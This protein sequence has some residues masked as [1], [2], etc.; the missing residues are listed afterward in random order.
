MGQAWQIGVS[1]PPPRRYVR[2]VAGIPP[3]LMT[4]RLPDFDY[5]LLFEVN[6]GTEQQVFPLR[7]VVFAHP[8]LERPRAVPLHDRML[9]NPEFLMEQLRE[10]GLERGQP[11]RA[12]AMDEEIPRLTAV[13][14]QLGYTAP[15][16]WAVTTYAAQKIS[17]V[18][19]VRVSPKHFRAVAKIAFHYT[20]K[21][22]PEL[23]GMEREFDGIKEFIWASADES[24][25]VLQR[26]DQFVKNFARGRPTKWM[27]T[28]AVEKT[29]GRIIAHAQFFAGP[30][31]LPPPYLIW[32]G[33]NPARI[34]R[35]REVRAHMFVILD[36][37][38]SSGRMEN[39]D[40][41]ELIWTPLT[42]AARRQ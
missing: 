19:E 39:A 18:A 24:K 40:P 10:W 9:D 28:L 2:R 13:L 36:P 32:I 1:I 6:P 37:E 5:D 11:I 41:A 31:I 15:N 27:H 35:R 26:G 21:M 17:L 23:T 16:D 30:G 25:F 12:F 7:Q 33:R 8:L 3:I 29:Y 42:Q 4:G 38:T 14:Q 22:C 34:D 20:L